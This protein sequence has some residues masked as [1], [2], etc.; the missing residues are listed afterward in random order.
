[1]PRS[2]HGAP[3]RLPLESG[4][5]GKRIGKGISHRAVARNARR[6]AP[7]RGDIG[8]PAQGLDAFVDVTQSFFKPHHRFAVCGEAEMSRLDDPGMDRPH[9]DLMQPFTLGGQES[10]RC[11]RP[12]RI[13]FQARRR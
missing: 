3:W 4:F 9:R 7:R 6:N 12:R 13:F 5:N 11:V 1:M 10:V 8:S 2:K